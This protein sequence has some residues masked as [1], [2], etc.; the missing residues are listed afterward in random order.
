MKKYLVLAVALGVVLLASV[1]AAYVKGRKDALIDDFKTYHAN[2]VALESRATSRE[3]E[4]LK[5]F[6]KSRYYYFGN[7]IPR[8]WLPLTNLDHGPVSTNALADLTIGKGPTTAS[9]EY[10]KFKEAMQLSQARK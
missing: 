5:E 4:E 8:D 1:V 10:R 7:R 2:L 6:V 3:A 9:E